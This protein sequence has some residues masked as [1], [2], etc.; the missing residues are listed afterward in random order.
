LWDGVQPGNGVFFLSMS[1]PPV[2]TAHRQRDGDCA[3]VFIHGFSGD[4]AKTWGQFP[5]FVAA[6]PRLSDWDIYSFGY[7]T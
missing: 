7:T 6:D 5:S 3:V 2:L 4:P 1:A